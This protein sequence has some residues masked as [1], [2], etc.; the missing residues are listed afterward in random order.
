MTK[1]L[2]RWISNYRR[3]N[4]LDDDA[5]LV[6]EGRAIRDLSREAACAARMHAAPDNGYRANRDDYM[7]APRVEQRANGREVRQRLR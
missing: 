6:E 5:A 3:A 4:Q 2:A 7:Y 1:K